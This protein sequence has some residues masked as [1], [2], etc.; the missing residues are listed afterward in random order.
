MT[1][2]G[3]ANVGPV[4][5]QGEYDGVLPAINLVVEPAVGLLV[6]AAAARN[7]NRP[8]LGALA[9]NGSVA[10]GNGEVSVSIG[11]PNL[12]PY[13]S[14]DLDLSIERYFGKVGYV[15]AALF[16]KS[17]DGFVTNRTVNNVAFGTTGLPTSLLPGLTD[18]TNVAAFSRPVNIGKTDIKGIELSGQSDFTFLP[19]PFDRFGTVLNLTLIEQDRRQTI[20]QPLAYAYRVADSVVFATMRRLLDDPALSDATAREP[21][22]SPEP[23]PRPRPVGRGATVAKRAGRGLLAAAACAALTVALPAVWRL[24]A[25]GRG[26]RQ[27]YASAAT[28]ACPTARRC[29]SM[30]RRASPSPF[31]ARRAISTCWRGRRASTC[32]RTLDGPHRHAVR[33]VGGAAGRNAVPVLGALSA[34][35]AAGAS[36]APGKLRADRRQPCP[37]HCHR[38]AADPGVAR[39]V[40]PPARRSRRRSGGRCHGS[41][42]SGRHARASA[43]PLPPRSPAYAR[44]PARRKR[45]GHRPGQGA[46]RRHRPSDTH[47]G[48]HDRRDSPPAR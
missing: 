24:R 21:A 34:L 10:R 30:P 33:P 42:R 35:R 45:S 12:R 4:T 32:A 3:V 8:G 23:A 41:W 26:E 31:R 7:I 13:K 37:D 29:R 19:A 48:A 25:P 9:V 43:S 14:T 22:L 36:P 27:V 40:R 6:R 18:A 2:T 5:V 16:C 11:N 1:S 38:I 28:R 20:D 39:M 17:L 44:P 47:A 46:V 15:A